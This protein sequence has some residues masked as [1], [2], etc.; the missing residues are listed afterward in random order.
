MKRIHKFLNLS[1]DE[2]R[3]FIKT[4]VLL[5][6]IKLGLELVPFSTLRKLLFKLTSLLRNLG[7]DFSEEYL[8]W[9]VAVASPY[10]PKTTC[11]AQALAAQLLLQRAGYQARLHIGVNYGIGGRLEAHAWVE[12]KGRIL[13]GGFDTNRY[14]HLLA[15]E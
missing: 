8:V 13:I 5:G 4:W 6:V 3:L 11:L 1:S 10:V 15:L 7:K 9:S 12:S 2:R 14:T